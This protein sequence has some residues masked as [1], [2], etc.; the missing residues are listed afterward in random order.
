MCVAKSFYRE[1]RIRRIRRSCPKKSDSFTSAKHTEANVRQA[2]QTCL[3]FCQRHRNVY[4]FPSLLPLPPPLVIF[5]Q[6]PIHTRAYTNAHAHLHKLQIIMLLNRCNPSNVE[7]VLQCAA[8]NHRS[9]GT[10]LSTKRQFRSV[11]AARSRANFY[12]AVSRSGCENNATEG[13]VEH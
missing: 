6:F 11:N 13:I 4:F 2:F 8:F 7:R 12:E 3:P 9:F 5:I 1:I 10:F